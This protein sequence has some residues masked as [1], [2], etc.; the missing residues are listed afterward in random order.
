M[1]NSELDRLREAYKQAVERWIAAIRTE[2]NLATA[3]HHI[4]AVD[5]WEE[6]GF[7]EEEARAKAK[8]A[9]RDYEDALRKV[10]FN[11]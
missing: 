10:N 5:V 7:S 3:D 4:P 6:A 1:D 11:F 8:D 9:R 2:E